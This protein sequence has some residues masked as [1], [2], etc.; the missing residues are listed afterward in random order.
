VLGRKGFKGALLCAVSS[1]AFAAA[2]AASAQPITIQSK[3][4]KLALDEYVKL[5]NA[6]LVYRVDE[7]S[8][9]KSHAVNKVDNPV[10]ALDIMLEG[11]GITAYRDGSGAIVVSKP[12]QRSSDNLQYAGTLVTAQADT[13]VASSR[14]QSDDSGEASIETV[15]ITGSRIITNG[16]QA[17]TPITV[18]TAAQLSTIT[19]SNIANGINKLPA[20]A[21]TSGQRNTGVA[22]TNLVGNFLDLRAFGAQRTLILLD[23]N[24]VPATASNGTV[25]IDTLPQMLVERVDVV[26]GGASAV[27][28]SD[29][30]TGVVNFVLDR[31]F[32]GLK[33]EAL[34][35]VS[36]RG[37]DPTW[38]VGVAAGRNV[39]G[40]RGHVEFSFEHFF[41]DGIHSM[42]DRPLGKYVYTESGAGSVANPYV[43]TINSRNP[44]YTP[45]GYIGDSVLK[46]QFFVSN[47][48]LAPYSH[49]TK[50]G[51]S[52][53][54]SGGDGGYGG[55][56]L[57]GSGANPWLLASLKTDLLFGRFDYDV[58]DN[59]HAYV[60]LSGAQAVNYDPYF[61]QWFTAKIAANNPYLPAS[62]QQ[63]LANAGNASFT[64]SKSLQGE[65]AYTSAGFTQNAD[66]TVGFT[67]TLFDDFNWEAHYTHGE[68]RLHESDPYNINQQ[69]LTAAL[70]ATINPASGQIVCRVSLNPAAAAQYP[71]CQ[72]FNALGPTA[73]N[74]GAMSYVDGYTDF[75][76]T[77]TIDDFAG[78]ISGTL[79][80]EWAGPLKAA[81]SGEYRDFTLNNQSN[82]QPTAKVDCTYLN[83]VTCDASKT[84]WTSDVG[85]PMDAS[86]NVWEVAAEIDVP[87]IK[88]LPLVDLFSV[89]AA[90]RYTQYSVSGP[91]TTWKVG[92]V[93]TVNDDITIRA[94]TSRD[95]RAPS[96][97]DLYAPTSVS[98]SGYSDILTGK[99]GNVSFMNTGN[100]SL[101]SEVARTTTMGII[102]QP[103]WLPRLSMAMDYY[104]IGI[105]NAITA[106]SGLTNSIQNECIA[107]GG[108]SPFCALY[109]R[110]H[111]I[112]DTS[113]GNYPTA[114]LSE[115]LNVAKTSTHGIDAE[116]NYNID[117]ATIDRVL[118]GTLNAR[119]LVSY[120]PSLLTKSTPIAVITN[121]AGGVMSG[122][123]GLSAGRVT[124]DI[125]YNVGAWSINAEERYYSSMHQTDNPTLVFL[126]PSIPEIYYTDVTVDYHFNLTGDDTETPYDAF[127]SVQNLFDQQP[128]VFS[129]TGVTGSQGFRYPTTR[130]E[131]VI[132]R[133]FTLGIRA[134]L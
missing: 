68:S 46:D 29:A 86:E 15:V 7:V 61:P 30:V 24:R 121:G 77:N 37:D 85:A 20:F 108:T 112:S 27:Y 76:L 134:K 75:T 26:T 48:V 82:F 114:V 59:V 14:S 51:S 42:L 56:G 118:A 131:D 96:L 88:G 129:S 106:I 32:T 34:A 5:S 80:E 84:L 124:F 130:E 45:G 36:S 104:Q 4:L 102:Y 12:H 31:N 91:A 132:G 113:A 10:R 8:N 28:G 43:L 72:P 94:T 98:L 105:N 64:L 41:N 109:V 71:G 66:A 40:N 6:Q 100:P 95:I 33:F 39:F 16:N 81:L 117:L 133:Y 9:I 55:Q 97:Y 18:I 127:L 111:P 17:P 57:P 128:H 2:S 110:P 79:I 92:G 107:S 1:I 122:A 19:P 21:V 11:T 120:Q 53:D 125:G 49:G 73:E 13:P 123:R 47:G 65:H 25:D 3:D 69:R 54:E 89:N 93:W 70:D 78:S 35:G 126:T 87:L 90:A 60:Q 116:V 22:S 50:T 83:P 62:A 101:K 67:G 99:G 115:S 58:A 119:L 74:A 63:A 23:G 38:K 103:S 44:Q 52:G